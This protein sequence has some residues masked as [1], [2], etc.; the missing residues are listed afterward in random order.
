MATIKRLGPA[1]IANAAADILTTPAAGYIF[2]LK[3]IRV[4]NTGA[5]ATYTLYIGGT[6]GSAGGTEIMGGGASI[7]ANDYDEQFWPDGLPMK[8]TDYLSGVSNTASR[9]TISGSYESD[10]I[11]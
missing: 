7:A 8:N 4:Q 2:R 10:V 3:K 5:A 11:P 6:G 9:L 1:Y